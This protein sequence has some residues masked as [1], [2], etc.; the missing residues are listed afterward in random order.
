[1]SW[2]ADRIAEL[3]QL[4]ARHFTASQVA[5]RMGGGVTRN[6][7]LGKLHRENGAERAPLPKP[8]RPKRKPARRKV[9]YKPLQ[10]ELEPPLEVINLPPDQSPFACSIIELTAR[11]CRWPLD[12]H[13]TTDMPMRYCGAPMTSGSY[14]GRHARLAWKP[15]AQRGMRI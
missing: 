15:G 2:T 11:S 8:A 10:Q 13:P 3:K 7:V 4:W 9:Q 6:A 1:M 14:C 12:D 5:S